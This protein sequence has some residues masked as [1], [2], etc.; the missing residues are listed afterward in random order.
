MGGAMDDGGNLLAW[1]RDS[2]RLPGIKQTEAAIAA[3]QPDSH[4]LTVLPLWAG[5]R[6]PNWSLDATGAITGLRL[7][8]SPLEV[9]RAALEA[10][11]IRFGE[12]QAIIHRA[13]PEAREVVAS[14]GALLHSPAWMQIMADV[15]DRPVIASPV[16]EASSRG[17]ALMALEL[18]GTLPGGVEATIPRGR[19]VFRPVAGHTERYRAEAGRQARLYEEL[20][21]NS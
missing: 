7:E 4:G 14:G 2:L 12:V 17:A 6:S 21:A 13:I 15:L 18:L 9:F 10:V 1:L 19:T 20:I 11:A 5:E 16:L 3:M 8:T